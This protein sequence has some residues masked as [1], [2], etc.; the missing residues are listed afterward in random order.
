MGAGGGE[1]GVRRASPRATCAS[2]RGADGPPPRW[3]ARFIAMMGD[4]E[5]D[6][7][8]VWEAL[9]EEAV[10]EL[11]NLLWVV[12]F[13]RQSLDRIVPD[14]RRGQL[15]EWFRGAGWHVI[16]LRWGG[17]AARALFR[18]VPGGER[19]ARAARGDGATRSTSRCCACRPRGAPQGGDRH[20]G[21]GDGTPAVDRL[22]ADVLRRRGGPRSWPTWAATIWRRSWRPMKRA[23][24]KRTG[25]CVILA[26]TIKGWGYPFGGDPM[27]HSAPAD[28]GAGRG[29]ARAARRRG[30]GGMGRLRSGQRR[31]G[32]HPPRAPRRTPPPEGRRD[33]ALG[34]A[35][36]A[37]G[38]LSAAELDPGGLRAA[39]S[40][41]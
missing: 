7:G 16:E 12:D 21:G 38:I 13:N 28:P 41:G 26:D 4:A 19:L 9:L 14:A 36:R 39:S 17:A 6:E 27:N 8:N 35:G 10:R 3:P 30:R 24:R 32:A 1:R 22:L 11:D 18:P 20:R 5:L 2:T 15:R 31:G 25:P 23:G 34:R 40:A 29:D 33:A 37:G